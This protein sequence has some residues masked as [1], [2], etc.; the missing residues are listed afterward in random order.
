MRF[1][2]EGGTEL[3]YIALINGKHKRFHINHLKEYRVPAVSCNVGVQYPEYAVD[4][5]VSENHERSFLPTRG[6]TSDKMVY[7]AVVVQGP[8]ESGDRPVT[9]QTC[10]IETFRAV[11]LAD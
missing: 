7:S 5:C 4:S 2:N 1:W 6:C 3:N 9:L 8:E 10:Q 11:A